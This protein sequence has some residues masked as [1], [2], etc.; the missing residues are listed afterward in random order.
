MTLMDVAYYDPSS[1]LVWVVAA[2][3][4]AVVAVVVLIVVLRR[5]GPSAG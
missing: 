2:I 5:R 3:A 4:V 1:P